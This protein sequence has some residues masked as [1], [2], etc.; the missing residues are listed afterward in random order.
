MQTELHLVIP[1]SLHVFQRCKPS[2]IFTGEHTEQPQRTKM[3]ESSWIVTSTWA[4]LWSVVLFSTITSACFN[5]FRWQLHCWDLGTILTVLLFLSS[6][7]PISNLSTCTVI[8][9]VVRVTIQ[10][11]VLH[12]LLW[13]MSTWT[14]S[15]SN[16]VPSCAFTNLWSVPHVSIFTR[17]GLQSNYLLAIKSINPLWCYTYLWQH[18]DCYTTMQA[19]LVWQLVTRMASMAAAHTPTPYLYVT[20]CP[21]LLTHNENIRERLE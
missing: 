8:I 3:T 1:A 11:S 4:E 14:L 20:H 18:P 9:Y 21:A 5:Q 7:D 6:D 15:K 10:M 17:E 13:W 2:W 16:V 19:I 12:W